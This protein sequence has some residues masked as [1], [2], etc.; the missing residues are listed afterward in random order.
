MPLRIDAHQHF[1]RYQPSEYAWIGDGMRQLR[2]D[3]LPPQL[4]PLLAER[5]LDGAIAVQARQS[6]Q[7]TRW[8]LELS[9]EHDEILAVVGWIDLAGP[10]LAA[11]L[12]EVA[13][14]AK[15]RGFRHQIQDEADGA[16]W[17]R[18]DA[19]AQGMRQI[20]QAGYVYDLLVTHR[21]LAAAA[22]FA[23]RHDGGP[24]VLDHFGKPDIAAGVAQWVEQVTPLAALP[25]VS[26]KLSGLLTE[27]RPAGSTDADLL[28]FY[29]AALDLFGPQR[30]LFGSDWPVCLLDGPYQ[31]GWDLCR[32]AIAGLSAAEQAAILGGNAGRIY[33]T[34]EQ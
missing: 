10:A 22:E 29:R 24:L 16:G 4:A 5:G 27:P 26:C 11:S 13:G 19:V 15:L 14:Q 33:L 21:Q 25:H 9:R 2:D 12:E 8:L 7:E 28:A 20:Q 18:Q 34:G 3:F 31:H 32:Q 6:G 23:A 1:W 30:L 17:M